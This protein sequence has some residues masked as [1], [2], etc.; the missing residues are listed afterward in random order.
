MAAGQ[1]PL[2]LDRMELAYL[3]LPT[4]LHYTKKNDIEQIKRSHNIEI[5]SIGP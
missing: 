5:I 2:G 4:F 1:F 3:L